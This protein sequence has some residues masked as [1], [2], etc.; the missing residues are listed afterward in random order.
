MR[1]VIYGIAEKIEKIENLIDAFDFEEKIDEGAERSLN[2]H[3]DIHV[4]IEAIGELKLLIKNGTGT[5]DD[6]EKRVQYLKL[7]VKLST[8][9]YALIMR[10]KFCL[11]SKKCSRSWRSILHRY[12]EKERKDAQKFLSFF[13]NPSLKNVSILAVFDPSEHK[14]LAAFL[15]EMQITIADLSEV[16]DGGTFVIKSIS[17]KEP[18]LAVGRPFSLFRIVRGMNACIDNIRIRFK[19]KA[20]ENLSSVFYIKSP[21]AGE[22]LIMNENA[23]C[24]YL[25]GY[26]GLANAQWRVILICQQG[27]DDEFR[28]TFIF[29]TRKW[30]HKFLYLEESYWI[31]AVGLK[32]GVK[33]DNECLFRLVDVTADGLPLSVQKPPPVNMARKA[34]DNQYMKI[35]GDAMG[36][37]NSSN[38]GTDMCS[39]SS[40]TQTKQ[41]PN[42]QTIQAFLEIKSISIPNDIE[43]I[44]IYFLENENAPLNAIVGRIAE[45]TKMLHGDVFDEGMLIGLVEMISINVHIVRKQIPYCSILLQILRVCGLVMSCIWMTRDIETLICSSIEND[46]EHRKSVAKTICELK[47]FAAYLSKI[48]R[49][50]NIPEREINEMVVNGKFCEEMKCLPGLKEKAS[51]D[52][53]FFFTYLQLSVLQQTILWQMFAVA[54][55]PGH[56]ESTANRLHKVLLLQKD[57]DID[58]IEMFP[59]SSRSKLAIADRY[60]S[61]LANESQI[62]EEKV[63]RTTLRPRTSWIGNFPIKSELELICLRKIDDLKCKKKY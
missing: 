56:S 45:N 58:F 31:P 55:Q 11:E 59:E 14:E 25:K 16:L 22:F 1:R 29:C 46:D 50:E 43:I 13:S 30:P 15:K 61:C 48:E 47:S 51:D 49:T 18:P 28:S 38:T 2:T 44:K 27:E 39:Y 33:P 37:A 62:S 21:D 4:G 19:F 23:S 24:K 60:L 54:K 40:N 35:L 32:E 52:P 7:F 6:P 57:N 17:V 63:T 3:V 53:K 12:I 10:Y 36:T 34:N 26:H 5:K 41:F 8:M 42:I 9:R 20:V